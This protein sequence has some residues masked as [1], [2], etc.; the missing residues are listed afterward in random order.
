MN[1]LGLTNVRANWGFGVRYEWITEDGKSLG[2]LN[3]E[4]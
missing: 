3:N 1:E 4:P 2:D